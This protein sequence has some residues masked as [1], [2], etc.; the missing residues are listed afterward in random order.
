M[1]KSRNVVVL[2]N[3]EISVFYAALMDRLDFLTKSQY[4]NKANM[5]KQ[6]KRIEQMLLELKGRR[7]VA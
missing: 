7:T 6:A 3:S 1:L 4:A 5:K 2:Q